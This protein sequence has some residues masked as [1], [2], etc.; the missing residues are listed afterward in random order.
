M[1]E[2]SY[3][4]EMF[5]R[6]SRDP[7]FQSFPIQPNTTQHT[8]VHNRGV[9][10]HCIGNYPPE[11]KHPGGNLNPS[12]PGTLPKTMFANRRGD[13]EIKIT[14]P[15]WMARFT[16][17]TFCAP[18]DANKYKTQLQCRGPGVKSSP[19]RQRRFNHRCAN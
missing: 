7:V 10:N 5:Y 17:S 4:N 3:K 16:L 14:T 6:V 19:D 2:S 9:T 1:L 11:L 13:L 12:K 8:A 15:P 18:L